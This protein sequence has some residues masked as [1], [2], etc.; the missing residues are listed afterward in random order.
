MKKSKIQKIK[1]LIDKTS[2][3]S[4]FNKILTEKAKAV[5]ENQII[6]KNDI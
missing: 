6:F 4:Q 5:A 2:K 1:E 3:D